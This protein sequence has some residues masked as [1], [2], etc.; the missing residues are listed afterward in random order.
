MCFVVGPRSRTLFSR[1]LQ[2]FRRY[3]TFKRDNQELLFHLLQQM[4]RE[5]TLYSHGKHEISCSA[6]EARVRSPFPVSSTF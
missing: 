6:F 4:V 5:R 3:I 2:K 1:H